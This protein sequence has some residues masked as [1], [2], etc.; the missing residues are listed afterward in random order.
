[1]IKDKTYSVKILDFEESPC[2]ENCYRWA[3]IELDGIRMYLK[4]NDDIQGYDPFFELQL[5]IT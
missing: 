4:A 2:G 3:E 5:T 1:M